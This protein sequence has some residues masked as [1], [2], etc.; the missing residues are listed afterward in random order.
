MSKMAT[1]LLSTPSCPHL[2]NGRLNLFLQLQ[3][4]VVGMNA[5][6]E[7][8]ATEAFHFIQAL[9]LR[10]GNRVQVAVLNGIERRVLKEAFRQAS[11]LQ[12]RIR[13]DFGL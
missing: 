2:F 3:H 6:G 5:K 4:F 8:A 10:H 7:A 13:M 9:R 12:Q 11:L 1:Y